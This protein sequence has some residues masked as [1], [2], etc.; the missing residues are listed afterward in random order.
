MPTMVAIADLTGQPGSG[1]NPEVL[2]IAGTL[3][4]LLAGVNV[5]TGILD[6]P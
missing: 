2:A 5:K 3:R 4:G 6:G 1:P